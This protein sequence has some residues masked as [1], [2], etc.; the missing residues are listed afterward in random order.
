MEVNQVKGEDPKPRTK[1]DDEGKKIY[2]K[3]DMHE[4]EY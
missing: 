1:S 3:E 2:D 4:F